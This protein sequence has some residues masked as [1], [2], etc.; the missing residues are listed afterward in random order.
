MNWKKERP[1]CFA[2]LGSPRLAFILSNRTEAEY[3]LEFPA[4]A[5]GYVYTEK[6][7]RGQWGVILE[8]RRWFKAMALVDSGRAVSFNS[9]LQLI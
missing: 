9:A 4:S 8:A 7:Q 2:Q 6:E 1:N 3:A 5:S